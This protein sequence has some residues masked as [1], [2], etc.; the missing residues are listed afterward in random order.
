MPCTVTNVNTDG[1]DASPLTR[2]KPT[3]NSPGQSKIQKKSNV[4]DM[5]QIT[6]L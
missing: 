4:I 6:N 1:T 5:M 3:T 2:N